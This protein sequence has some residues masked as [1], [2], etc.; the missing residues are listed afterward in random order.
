MK[1]VYPAIFQKDKE[2][3]ETWC[4]SFPDVEGADTYGKT[5][6]EAM[7]MAEDA[8]SGILVMYED[9]KMGRTDLPMNNRIVKPTPI[10]EVVAEPDEYSSD[11]FVTLIKVDTDEYRR[12]ITEM[13]IKENAALKTMDFI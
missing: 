6:Y 4:V 12:A 9:H 10:K 5:L 2:L 8:L 3:S 1:Y 11:A 13:Q 7:E